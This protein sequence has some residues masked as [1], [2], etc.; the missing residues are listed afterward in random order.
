MFPYQDVTVSLDNRVK[1]L[2]SRLTLEEKIGFLPVKMEAVDRLGIKAYAAEQ[3]AAHGLVVR[4]G[5]K[6][7]VFPQPHG[8][9]S[10]WDPVLL[11]EV[12]NV[13]G[14]ESRAYYD[15]SDHGSFLGLFFPTIDMERDPR[16]GRNEEAYGED[17]HLAGKLGSAIISGAQGDDPFYIKAVASPKHFYANN[18]ER[19]RGFCDSVLTSRLKWEYYLRVFSYAFE[20]GNAM[21]LMTAYNR[22]DG[23]PGMVNPELNTLLRDKWGAEG[24]FVT[25]GG[26]FRLL[27][28]FHQYVKTY[29]EGFAL[30]IKAGID[31]FL[32]GG[33]LVRKSAEDALAKK[34]VTEADIDTAVTHILKVRTRL[35]HFDADTSKNPYAKITRSALCT[36]QNS[37]IARKAAREAVVLLKNDGFLPLDPGKTKKIAVIGQLGNE[38]MPDWYSGNAPYEVTPLAGIK[39]AF[40]RSEVIY[41]D[42]CDTIAIA[43]RK[44]GAWLRVGAD[45]AVTL[46]GTEANRAVFRRSDWGYGG[47]GIME[48]TSGKYLTTREDGSLWCDSKALW[49]WFVR[50]LFFLEGDHFLPEQSTQPNRSVGVAIGQRAS[51]YNKS[52]VEGAI[53]TLNSLLADLTITTL[54]DGIAAAAEAAKDADAAVVVLG[55][56]TLVGA[57]ECI[58]RDDLE[59]PDR[60]ASLLETVTKANSNTVLSLI[61]GYPYALEKQEAISRAVLFTT[62]GAQEV[63]TA[64]AE[65]IAGT[66]SPAGRL[67][68]TWYKNSKNF[69]DLNDYDIVKNKMTYLYTDK[70]V[71]HPFGFGLSYTKF[72]YTGLTVTKAAGGGVEASFTVKNSGTVA[73]DEVP[74]LYFASD[75]KDLSRPRKQLCGFSRIYLKPGEEQK[76]TYTVPPKELRFWDEQAQALKP[77][78]GKYRFMAGASSEDIRLNAE[79]DSIV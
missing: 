49:G 16:W 56:H 17:P 29:E 57:R 1:D 31:V 74:Q 39:K 69:P 51:I 19:D 8:L 77:D 76:V 52:Y 75:R 26:A 79:L 41:T 71:L 63:G 30:A 62:H 58:D 6:S 34:L 65:A 61:A 28:M 12:G 24:Y 3:E 53:D 68:M 60:W 73:G 27:V 43:S 40:P 48:V 20:E 67:S 25:D 44:T 21:S 37:A 2:L 14:D 15:I 9:S 22:I 38:N 72:D 46:D 78:T 35:G 13:I 42:G 70:P 55:N 50:E 66:F 10:T 11:K 18:F 7:T 47:F 4:D 36:E 54:K 45:G 33:D 59:F 64:V 32:D 5:G 23:V